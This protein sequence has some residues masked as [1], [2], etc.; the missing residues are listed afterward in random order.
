MTSLESN[1]E[2]PIEAVQNAVQ[3][4]LSRPFLSLIPQQIA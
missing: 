2:L 3:L 1:P 4:T